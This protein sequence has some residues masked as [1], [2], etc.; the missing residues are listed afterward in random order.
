V[1][2]GRKLTCTDLL[3]DPNAKPEIAGTGNKM[4]RKLFLTYQDAKEDFHSTS[5]K[6]LERTKSAKWLRDTA[7]NCLTYLAARIDSPGSQ[8]PFDNILEVSDSKAAVSEM[9]LT[10][11]EATEAAEE[12]SGGKKRRFDEDWTSIPEAPATMRPSTIHKALPSRDPV[13][14]GTVSDRYPRG[15]FIPQRIEKQ[16]PPKTGYRSRRA[17]QIDRIPR[18]LYPVSA[19]QGTRRVFP[20][21]TQ[22]SVRHAAS[23]SLGFGDCYRPAYK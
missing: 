17:A 19:G 14:R 16:S 13:P 12:G 7:E 11:Q 5:K 10:L 22:G 18:G 23:P 9:K 3:S 2:R 6:S 4:F 1:E 20:M 15:K 8:E 21:P